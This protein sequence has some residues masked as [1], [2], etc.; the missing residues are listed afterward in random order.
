M[1]VLRERQPVP[2][3]TSLL[4]YCL[5]DFEKRSPAMLAE[6]G[7]VI[8]RAFNERILPAVRRWQRDAERVARKS[9]KQ[10]GLEQLFNKPEN[11]NAPEF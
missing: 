5:V 6:Q 11:T 3:L 7:E 10:A 8:E 1:S 2:G 4:S 9:A